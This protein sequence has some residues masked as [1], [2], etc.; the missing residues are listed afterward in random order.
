VTTP[1]GTSPTTAADKFTYTAVVAPAV[2]GL[3]PTSGPAA[4]GTSVTITGSGFTGTTAVNFGTTAATGFTVVNDTKITAT[5]PAGTGAV[6]VTVTTPA[7]TSPTTAADKF[8]FNAVAAPTVTGISPTNGPA[9]GGSLV[10]ITGTGFTGATAVNFGTVAATNL[11]VVNDATITATS[12]A[13]TGVVDVTVTTPAGTSP[14]SSADQFTFNAVAAPTVS[15]ISPTSGPASGGTLVTITGTGFTGATAVNFG[16]T[17]GTGLTVVNGT[18]ITVTS[19]AGTGT[20]AV[21]VVTP[22]GTSPVTTSAQFTFVAAGAP[23]VVSL[24]RY[25]FHAQQTSLVLTF[26]TALAAGP[27]QNVNNYQIMTENGTVI[28]VT[29]AVYD[30]TALTVTLIP[31]Q[32]L[33]LQSFYQLSVTGTTPGGLTSSTGVPLDGAG[34]GTPGTNFV[35]M[36]SGGILAGPSPAML[37]VSPKIFAAAQKLFDAAEKKYAAEPDHKAAAQ[38]KLAVAKRNF[39]LVEKRLIAQAQKATIRVRVSNAVS[40]SGVDELSMLGALIVKPKANR[41]QIG[42]HQPLG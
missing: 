17:P 42:R 22:S 24:L 4:G 16:T 34:N 31:A 36:F 7:G 28:P 35:K 40:A 37:S 33:T 38:R 14:V 2:T 39:A 19:P 26:S 18:T 6:D 32:R 21:T 13:G 20:S 41:V 9:T 1:A 11:T 5:S 3:N 30:P 25:G 27:A 8:T 12:P 10:T 29:S 23:T 15:G